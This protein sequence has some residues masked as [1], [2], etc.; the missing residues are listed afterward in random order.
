MIAIAVLMYLLVGA[1]VSAFVVDERHKG[2]PAPEWE[3]KFEMFIVTVLWPAFL[4]VNGT[5]W[6]LMK[7]RKL[8]RG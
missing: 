7:L 1:V 6:A 8:V 2:F 3:I 4:V 5:G